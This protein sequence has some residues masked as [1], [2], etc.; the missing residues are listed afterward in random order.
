MPLISPL[1]PVPQ[2]TK[3]TNLM[4]LFGKQLCIVTCAQVLEEKAAVGS[5]CIGVVRVPM[6][7][8]SGKAG[9]VIPVDVGL[10]Q[11]RQIHRHLLS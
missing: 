1:M 7:A 9:Q 8:G 2:Q 5:Q 10:E 3:P 11:L 4:V 6:A